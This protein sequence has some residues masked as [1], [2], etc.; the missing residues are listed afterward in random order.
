MAKSQGN[1]TTTNLPPQ[2]V[3]E[4]Q[5]QMMQQ[6]L[7]WYNSG[8]ASVAPFSADQLAS[9]DLARRYAG[10]QSLAD[11]IAQAQKTQAFLSNP[12]LLSPDSNP[13]LKASVEAALHP[14]Q[15]N[16]SQII[17]P[18]EN[19]TAAASGAYGGSRQG[20]V[21]AL[22]AQNEG[23][24]VADTSAQ[25]YSGAY[26]QGLNT[27]LSALGQSGNTAKL[28]LLPS[29]IYGSIGNIEQQQRQRELN[30][31]YNNLAMWGNLIGAGKGQVTTSPTSTVSP[32]ASA[33]G[34]AATGAA[35]GSE[36]Y[37]GWGTLIGAGIGAVG[38]YA[39]GGGFG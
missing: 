30:N 15:D 14:I 4:A 7:N 13:Y 11:Q 31:P 19:A 12:N 38:G 29:S 37:P 24:Q 26:Q 1:V 27:M 36:I 17:A 20:I 25:M 9:L 10:S 6:V 39:Q 3:Q 2:Y 33:L 34:G 32:G 28:G 23:R 22:N 35:M 5:K 21:Q 18:S 16:Y 8:G